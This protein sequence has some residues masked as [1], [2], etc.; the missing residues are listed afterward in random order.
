MR[1]LKFGLPLA[2]VLDSPRWVLG[3]A[4]G[5]MSPTTLKLE[6]RFD[7][8][9]ADQLTKMGH[10]VEWLPPYSVYA[11]HAGIIRVEENGTMQIA[12]DPRSDGAALGV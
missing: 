2:E 1:A 8:S 10:V 7:Q 4:W 12:A 9:V 3:R 11:G 6:Q 5:D